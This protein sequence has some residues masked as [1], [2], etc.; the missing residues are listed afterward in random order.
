MLQKIRIT[1]WVKL[2]VFL[3]ALLL[4]NCMTWLVTS[5]NQ[6]AGLYPVD[7]DSIGVPIMSTVVAS[8]FMLPIFLVVSLLSKNGFLVGLKSKGT[9][10]VRAVRIGLL[11]LYATALLF[12]G[13][14]IA[15]WT[16]PGHYLIAVSYL[17]L[18]VVL[19]TGLVSDWRGIDRAVRA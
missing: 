12:A 1:W 14:G 16:F 18:F 11:L 3:G 13:Y 10:R 7:A 6:S 15:Y 8:L 5:I 4:V 2:S 19:L 9:V 17:I